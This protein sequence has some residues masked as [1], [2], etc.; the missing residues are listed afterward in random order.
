MACVAAANAADAAWQC[1]DIKEMSTAL[2]YAAPIVARLPESRFSAAFIQN[3]GRLLRCEQDFDASA[4][5]LDRAFALNNQTGRWSNAA[6]V[7]DD[8]ALTYLGSG[9]LPAARDALR[10][11]VAIVD[12]RTHPYPIR[13][14]W[15]EACVHRASE[16]NVEARRALEIASDVFIEQRAA[17]TDPSVQASFE[18]IPVHRAVCRALERDVW[19]P[20][21]SPCIVAFPDRA[22]PA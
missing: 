10:R 3:R 5:E 11:S 1:G 2:Q 14:H 7:L 20:P 9:R 19:H 13:H 8:L 6:E 17:L 15:I 12:G 4:S 22:F 16:E 21:E 18:A